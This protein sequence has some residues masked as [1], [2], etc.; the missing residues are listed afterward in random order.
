MPFPGRSIERVLRDLATPSN[1]LNHTFCRSNGIEHTDDA[2][3]L[4]VV[5]LV[6]PVD[7]GGLAGNESQ[8]AYST[9]DLEASRISNDECG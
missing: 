8:I 2:V 9:K 4:I 6:S 7:L 3:M 1:N 5:C